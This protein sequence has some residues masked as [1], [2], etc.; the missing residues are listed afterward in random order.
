MTDEKKAQ[1]IKNFVMVAVFGSAI[2]LGYFV[3][4][5]VWSFAKDKEEVESV[6]E[7]EKLIR[8]ELAVKNRLTILNS[9]VD[10]NP[11]SKKLKEIL[12]KLKQEKYGDQVAVV[13]LDVEKQ[14]TISKENAVDME[15][16]AGQL[17]FYA[18]GEK[19]GTL[20]GQTDPVVVERTIDR[21]LA[22]LVKRFGPNWLPKVEGMVAVGSKTPRPGQS[23]PP[24]VARPQPSGVPGMER[25]GSGV[26]GM[27]RAKPGQSNVQVEPADQPKK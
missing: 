16:F 18:S 21:Y 4:L 13:D 23:A 26:P 12:E 9:M 15:E 22:G 25:T 14:L 1:L 24:A 3:K 8:D 10:G 6:A 2:A 11:D 7:E 19:L 27:T 5:P 20:K 17:D